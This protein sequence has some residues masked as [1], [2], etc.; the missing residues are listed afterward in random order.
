MI[1]QFPNFKKIEIS[2]QKILQKFTDKFQP[3]NDFELMSLWTYNK[4]DKNS[5]SILDDNLVIKIQDFITGNFLYSFIGINNIKDV[6]AKLIKRS[7]EEDLGSKLYLIP[8]I[9]IKS[10]PDLEK[11]FSIKEDPDS[12]EYILSV[13]ELSELKGHKYQD[14]RNMVNRFVRSYSEHTVRPLDLEQKKTKKDIEELFLFWEQKKGKN[15]TETD[16]EFTAIRRMFDLVHALRVTGVGIFIGDRLI[17]FSIFHPVQ[18]N[19]A[20]LSFEKGDTTYK[21]I[22][23]YINHCAAKHL[24]ELG[25]KYINYEQDLGIPGLKKAKMLW[26]PVFFLKKYII[27]EKV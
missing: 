7:K 10:S 24:K 14:K 12:F 2:D 16:I 5:F 21:G 1:P 27:E 13:Q 18:N 19:Y 4:G 17:G 11:Y 23:E 20:I 25:V 3:Y 9:N 6:T 15:R 26:R 8:E 22:Y